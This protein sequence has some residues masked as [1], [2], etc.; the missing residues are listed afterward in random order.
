MKTKM[1]YQELREYMQNLEKFPGCEKRARA[2]L[3]HKGF[4]GTFNLSFTEYEHLKEFGNFSNFN[5]DFIFSAIQSCIRPQD[6]DENLKNGKGLWKYLGIFEMADLAGQIVLSGKNKAEELHLYQIKRLVKMFNELGLDLTRIYPSYNAGGSVS[7]LTKG[8]YNFDFIIPEDT[9]S[10]ESFIAEGIPAENLIAD[11]TRDTFLSLHLNMKS[12]WGY[13]NEINYNI[14]TKENPQLLDIATLER[15]LWF[16]KYNGE[17][18]SLNICGLTEIDHTINVS[19]IG[20][21]RLCMAINKLS[22]VQEVDYIKSFYD[23]FR[24]LSPELSEEQRIKVGEVIRAMHRVQSDVSA[25]SSVKWTE[26]REKKR[27]RLMQIIHENHKGLKKEELEQLLKIHAETQ[28]WH[29]ELEQGITPT[30]DL[31]LNY[32]EARR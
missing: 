30:A 29:P 19:G 14:G 3:I 7:E 24:T 10:K 27:R 21:E 2:P 13:R 26:S 4:P 32:L 6:I 25:N 28:P 20:L 8:K 31:I 1:T 18:K 12:P 11:K 9:L 16:P 5:K 15:C 17:E 22:N 23:S